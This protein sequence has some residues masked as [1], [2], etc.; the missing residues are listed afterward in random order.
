MTDADSAEIGAE[1][2][3]D[4]LEHQGVECVLASPIVVLAL[5]WEA[6]TRRGTDIALRSMDELNA[7]LQRALDAV[8]SGRTFLLDV[9]VNP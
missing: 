4:Q 6:L 5:L 2:L 9:T 7:A 3:L 8:T 1:L